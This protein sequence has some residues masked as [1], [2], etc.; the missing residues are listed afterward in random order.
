MKRPS[1][2]DFPGQLGNLSKYEI[3]LT[4][5]SWWAEK[6]I[7]SQHTELERS[8]IVRW[9]KF[10]EKHCRPNYNVNVLIKDNDGV[11]RTAIF[12]DQDHE[13]WAST[14]RVENLDS[15]AV[16]FTSFNTL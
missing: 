4:E 16:Y 5:W 2:K 13:F 9:L 8:G 3:K 14:D 7:E 1:L 12:S 15:S 10:N 11:I 6:M